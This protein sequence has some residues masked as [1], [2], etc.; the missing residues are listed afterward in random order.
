[1]SKRQFLS[2]NMRCRNAAMHSLLETNTEDDVLF[3]QEPWFDRIGV[4]RS[5]HAR[6]GV[7]VHGGANHPDWELFYPY[8]TNDK[9]AKVM[10]YKRK[11]VA[12]RIT[13]LKVVPRLDLAKH[14][15]ILI[16][17]IYVHKD[18][19]RIVNFYNDMDD[20]TSLNTLLS[21]DLD[22][23]VPT[24]LLGDFNLH[25][26][27]WSPSS[28]ERSTNTPHFEQWAATQTFS[29]QTTP[30]D[31][32]RRGTSNEHPSTLDLTWHNWAM[33]LN[34]AITPPTLDWASSLG[35][36]HCGMCSMW[37]H[38][39]PVKGD[40][41]PFLNSFKNSLDPSEEKKWKES[42]AVA[43]PTI[44]PITDTT[45]LHEASNALQS[46]FD[47]ACDEHMTHKRMPKS[48]VIGGGPRSVA[49]H[50]TP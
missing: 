44:T 29:L 18:M 2:I 37:I 32:T 46:A 43:L 50:P 13:P 38:D 48:R 16:T 36:D 33:E 49:W 9:R 23:T 7:D 47:W 10:T 40:K 26:H 42:L 3:V 41:C 39:K 8:F 24:L 14:P 30:G 17:D 45:T 31:I 11:Q 20:T 25:S 1:M 12:N 6:E 15:T 4:E 35:S 22:P 5:D 28:W 21:F 19:I 34:V 27:T